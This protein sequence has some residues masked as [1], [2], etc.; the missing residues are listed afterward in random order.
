MKVS[1]ERIPQS[2]VVLQI[3]V[4]PERVE[5]S[6][7]AAYRRLVQRASVPGFR[8]GK[9]P[10]AMLERHLGRDVLLQEALDRLIPEVYREAVEAEEIEPIELPELEMV[11]TEPLVMKATVPIRPTIELGDY[12]SLRVPREPVVVPEERIDEALEGLRHRYANL[13]PVERPVRWGDFI[14]IDASISVG[15]R[16]IIEQKDVEFP[17]REGASVYLP[18]FADRLVGLEKGQESEFVLPVAEDYGDAGLAGKECACRVVVHEVKEE[19]LPPL[20]DSFARQVG[21]GFASLDALRERL[22]ADIRE[23]E[24]QAAM[25]RYRAEVI[26]VLEKNAR[27][28]YPPVLVEK[29]V[30][31]MLREQAGPRGDGDLERYLQ[32]AGKS[33]EQLREEMRPLAEQRLR[34]SLLLSKVAEVENIEVDESEVGQEIERMASS[35]GPQAD[36]IRRLFDNPGGREAIQGSLFTRKTWDRLIE[37]VSGA[38]PAEGDEE[39]GAEEEE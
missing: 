20:D 38:E 1:A 32:R 4:E 26:S 33:E 7:D 16:R 10:R 22:A 27:L 36:E 2:Q 13:E 11:S 29:E 6:L 5:K 15:N 23:A 28:E 17:L 8:K 3:E 19:K 21:E 14:R 24:E 39:T 18:G 9:A 37:I 34:R 12:R 35:A 25:D 31:R 30:D